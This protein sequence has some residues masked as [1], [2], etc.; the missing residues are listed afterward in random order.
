MCCCR[1]GFPSTRFRKSVMSWMSIMAKRR[2]RNILES[3]RSIPASF[4]NWL[5]GQSNVR[6]IYF[7]N[8]DKWH[9]YYN[10][11]IT[12][13]LSGLWHGANWTFAAWGILHGCY[14]I[15]DSILGP[16][17]D[18]LRT[19]LK[20][21]TAKNLFD[22]INVGFTFGLVAIAWIPFRAANFSDAWYIF[23]HLF[24]G[25]S[26]WLHPAEVAIQFRGMGL[27]LTEL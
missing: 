3:L 22:G 7:L 8:F 25:A 1:S 19:K 16:G 20:T 12:F 24:S 26:A 11:F 18:W 23:A 17:R 13:L 4:R 6:R 10:L 27:N 21:D 2:P 14:M 15:L 5:P 9:W